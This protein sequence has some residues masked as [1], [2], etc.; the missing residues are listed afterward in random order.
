MMQRS[1][2]TWKMTS[3]FFIF[4]LICCP[5]IDQQCISQKVRVLL[6][7]FWMLL[8]HSD[9]GQHCTNGAIT[10]H[11]GAVNNSTRGED[12]LIQGNMEN[13]NVGHSQLVIQQF[14]C[15]G[16]HSSQILKL[17]ILPGSKSASRTQ[18]AKLSS[19]TTATQFQHI[20]CYCTGPSLHFLLTYRA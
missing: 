18:C 13:F 3:D 19:A 7:L 11:N 20:V 5:A 9:R 6:V 12:H 17:H 16:K 14:S 10:Q 2:H 4:F 1:C 8:G 15:L